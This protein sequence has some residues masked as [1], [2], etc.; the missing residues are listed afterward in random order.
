MAGV[1]GLIGSGDW[2]V[3]TPAV[4]SS[5]KTVKAVIN[6]NLWLMVLSFGKINKPS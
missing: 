5:A 6:D 1:D 4:S 3:D 2:A